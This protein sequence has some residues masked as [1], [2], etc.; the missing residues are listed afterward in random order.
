V[1]TISETWEVIICEHDISDEILF[2]SITAGCFKRQYH[3]R[4]LGVE[5][6]AEVQSRAEFLNL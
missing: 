1:F 4:L 6:Q 2:I 5:A 3:L